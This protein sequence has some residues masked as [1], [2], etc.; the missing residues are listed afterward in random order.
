MAITTYA[1]LQTAIGDFLNRSD[2]TAIAPTFID[3]CEAD[4][5]RRLRHWRMQTRSTAT[6]DGQYEDLPSDFLEVIRLNIQGKNQIELAS[7]AEIIE[8]RRQYGDTAGQPTMYAIVAGQIE[9]YPTPDGSYTGELVYYGRIA[10]LNDGNVTNWVLSNH[11]DVYLYGSLVHSA[12]YLK[13]DPRVQVWRSLYETALA[14]MAEED[15]RFQFGGTGLRLRR[16]GL[17]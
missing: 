10:A 3:L 11:P 1:E 14:G 12:P 13:D 17:S 7:V 4:L 6:F 16:R 8:K 9:L 5:N 15:R 2:L